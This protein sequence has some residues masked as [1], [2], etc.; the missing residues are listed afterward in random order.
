MIAELVDSVL[1]LKWTV[2]DKEAQGG[3]GGVERKEKRKIESEK[4]RGDM[5]RRLEDENATGFTPLSALSVGLE[6][7]SICIGVR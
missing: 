2:E 3:G 5:M 1:R 4:R 7:F 6:G